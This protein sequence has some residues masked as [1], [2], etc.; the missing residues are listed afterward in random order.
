MTTT[1]ID[2]KEQQALEMAA[3]ML[4]AVAHPVRLALIELLDYGKRRSVTELFELLGMEQAV[5]SHHLS[6]LR[7]RGV[8]RQEREGKHVFY[9]LKHPRLIEIVRCVRDCCMVED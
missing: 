1:T 4:K 6:I 9:S 3:V 5:V 7:D 8:L 2:R